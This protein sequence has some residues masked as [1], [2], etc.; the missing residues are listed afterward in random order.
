MIKMMKMM[1]RRS[2]FPYG[3]G[4]EMDRGGGGKG[5]KGLICHQTPPQ[6]KIVQ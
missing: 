2:Y 5:V 6:T 3:H 4:K 1:N